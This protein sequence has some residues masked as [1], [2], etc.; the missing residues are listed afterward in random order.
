MNYRLFRAGV[1]RH[2]KDHLY[3]VMCLTHDAN[4]EQRICVFY[5][6]LELDKV[7][8]GPRHAVR[9][10]QDFY[11]WI[12][13]ASKEEVTSA[14]WAHKSLAAQAHAQ[15]AGFIRRFTYLGP[16]FEANMLEG[17]PPNGDGQPAL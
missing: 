10:Y 7:N 2:Y 9:T 5:I 15:E 17:A 14:E 13:L 3:E 6:G 12:N 4:D 1:Y 16:V 8:E 11:G